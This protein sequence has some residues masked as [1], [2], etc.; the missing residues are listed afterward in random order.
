VAVVTN[1]SQIS[2]PFD[3]SPVNTSK[4]TIG[5][6]RI[7]TGS[8][9]KEIPG[10]ELP[11]VALWFSD[12][13]H[14][15]S[16]LDCQGNLRTVDDRAPNQ[17]RSA[18]VDIQVTEFYSVALLRNALS[19]NRK[20]FAFNG[21]GRDIHLVDLD[22]GQVQA[23][24]LMPRKF[25]QTL[26]LSHDNQIVATASASIADSNPGIDQAV[27]LWDTKSGR[28]LATVGIPDTTVASMAFSPDG[29]WLVTGTEMGTAL[30]WDV[31]QALEK[32]P[33]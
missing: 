6:W 11:V 16:T 15:L 26:A 3:D 31:R 27:R 17:I 10:P 29:A 13:S 9:I 30:V 23:T 14:A 24:L 33:R 5:L 21:K 28:E 32:S 1:G 19:A 20:L 4:S 2:D 8:R 18:K 7:D 22:K 25:S 12:G